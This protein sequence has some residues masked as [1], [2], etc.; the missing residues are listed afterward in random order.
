MYS[1]NNNSDGG[2]CVFF[3][4]L[5]WRECVQEKASHTFGIRTLSGHGAQCTHAIT[6]DCISF[7]FGTMAEY[8]CDT[9]R[10]AREFTNWG[11]YADERD[12]RMKTGRVS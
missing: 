6:Y 4:S 10:K 2:V 11:K 9:L 12:S 3:P 1:R 8:K 7:Q 5:S